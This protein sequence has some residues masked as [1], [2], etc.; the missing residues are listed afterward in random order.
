MAD[1]H[2]TDR[3]EA[4]S[5]R[6]VYVERINAVVDHIE[7]HLDED[8]TIESLAAVAHFSPYHFHRVFGAL[9]G[10]TVGHFVTRVRIEK[11][12]TLLVQQPRR[13]VTEIGVACGFSN[14]SSLARTFR[15]AFGMS[16]SAW[17]DGGYLDYE[18]KPGE[19][20]RDTIGNIGKVDE[21]YGVTE[22]LYNPETGRTS[23]RMRCGT[24]G[25]ATVRIEG[26]PDLE[27]AYVRHTGRYQGLGEVFADLFRR[28]M[29]WAEPRGFVRPDAWLLAVYHDNPSITEDERLRVSVCVSVPA[30]TQASGDVG[31]MQVDRGLYAVGRFDLG[32]QD[33]PE[34]WFSM[35]GGWLPDSGYEPDDRYPFERYFL[36]GTTASPGKEAVEIWLPVRPLSAY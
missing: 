9:V 22:A 13:S 30:E 27:V 12:A 3:I 17:R 19:S 18:V 6:P 5:R 23:W 10:E 2:V 32:E 34:A 29:A 1:D 11:A 31:R 7:Q 16:A 24:L 15:E 8:L 21:T 33:Y 28:L 26:L 35:A 4:S 20:V 25:T 14:P 36:D